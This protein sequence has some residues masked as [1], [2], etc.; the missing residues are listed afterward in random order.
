[1]KKFAFINPNSTQSMTDLCVCNLRRFVGQDVFIK[2][3]TNHEGPAA[4]QGKADGEV[5]IK[6]VL[7]AIDTNPTCDGFII[8]CFDDTG[9]FE[10]RSITPKPVIGIGQAS[11]VVAALRYDRFHILT[12]LSPSVPVIQENV[13]R[14]GFEDKCVAVIASGVP[15][16][17]LEKNPDEAARI[18]S[19]FISTIEAKDKNQAVILGCA[20][21]TNIHVQLQSKHTVELIDPILAVEH[22]IR[23]G[24]QIQQT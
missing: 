6:G 22:L 19:N 12:T 16:L 2:A 21:M 23:G 11:F 18:L 7:N 4:I 20:G 1:M 13:N 24:Q 14:Q 10:A 5:A 17:E 15:V 3:I 9:L 8:G